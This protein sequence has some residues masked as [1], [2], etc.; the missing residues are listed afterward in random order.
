MIQVPQAP[1]YYRDPGRVYS[2]YPDQNKEL[3][4]YNIYAGIFEDEAL[5]ITSAIGIISST[6]KLSFYDGQFAF[7]LCS[8]SF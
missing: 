4:V 2:P 3:P 1:E 5:G 8:T 6:V 7:K